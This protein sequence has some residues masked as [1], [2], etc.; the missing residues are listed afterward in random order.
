M[1]LNND[2]SVAEQDEEFASIDDLAPEEEPDGETPAEELEQSQDEGE[3]T[4]QE[5]EARKL[6]GK[7][8]SAE[9]LEKAYQELEKEKSRLGNEVGQLRKEIDTYIVPE[10]QSRKE[11]PQEE[12]TEEDFWENPQKAIQDAV[13]QRLKP[14][15]EQLTQKQQEEAKQRLFQA[16]PD[17][18]EVVQNSEFQN[19]LGQNPMLHRQ[20]QEADQKADADAA[21]EILSIYK[22]MNPKQEKAEEPS[23]DSQSLKDASVES[24][25]SEKT[26]KK[27][28]FRR[29]DLMQLR[30]ENPQKYK[31]LWPEIVKAY[32]EGRV[33]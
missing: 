8:A 23:H 13:D 25:K 20:F 6:A 3:E 12:S 28:V 31:Q 26:N 14:V 5:K 27:K 29:V 2:E 4:E 1:K 30:R 11:Q 15:E 21:S 10:L 9:E 19:W 17:A 22:Q 32:E 16:H 24:S 7:F 33:K 18:M